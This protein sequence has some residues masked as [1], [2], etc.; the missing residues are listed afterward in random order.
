[1]APRAHL[2]LLMLAAAGAGAAPPSVSP[3]RL[4]GRQVKVD[5]SLD[6]EV[7]KQ[8]AV[9]GELTRLE[10]IEGGPGF[11][12]AEFRLFYDETA[13]YVGAR[14]EQPPGALRAHI[15]PRDYLG[16]DDAILVYL[17]PYYGSESSYV[18]KVNPLG[19]QRDSYVIQNGLVAIPW[20]GVWD[21]NGQVRDSGYSVE[22]RI[23][24]R[25]IRFPRADLQDWGFLVAVETG[26]QAQFDTWPALSANR[27]P[28]L[29]QLGKLA[30]LHGLKAGYDI[31]LLPSV[32]LRYGGRGA[33]GGG[34]AWDPFNLLNGSQ[35][36]LVDPGIDARYGFSSG[37]SA[38]LAINPDFSQVEADSD[39]LEYNIRYP[40]YLEE[41]RPFFLEGMDIFETPISLLYTRAINDPVGGLK[42][43][44]KEGRAVLGLLSG[45]D[46]VPPPTRIQLTSRS[47]APL[48][49]F[50]SGFEDMT[51]R[52]AVT[53]VGRFAYDVAPGARVG[54]MLADKRVVQGFGRGGVAQNDLASLDATVPFLTNYSVTGQA[55]L[56]RTGT[57][58]NEA[59][60]GGLY[61][62]RLRREDRSLLLQ[63]EA[64]YYSPDFRAETS[65]ITRVDQLPSQLTASYKIEPGWPWLA[66][67]RPELTA[68][69]VQDADTLARADWAL[70]PAVTL[71][72]AGNT[73]LTAGY[74]HGGERFAG[75]RFPVQSAFLDL[76]TSPLG[77]L[78]ASVELQGGSRIHYDVL[79]PFLGTGADAALLLTLRPSTASQIDLSYIKS[80]FWG[81]LS[82]TPIDDVDLM[83][84]KA[85]Y[86][87]TAQLSLRAILQLN[88]Y[89]RSL[90]SNLLLAYLYRPGTAV[91]LGVQ[92]SEP[93]GAGSTTPVERNVFVKLSYLWQ[94]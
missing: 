4:D 19:I 31:D 20:D 70:K 73:I 1:M 5:G 13:L 92:D 64:A 89:S 63:A 46:V 12:K 17:Q 48:P 22:L 87:F 10:P 77:W 94:L 29:S 23:P 3:P 40:L 36:G 80:L 90:Q 72:F 76:D 21:S 42:V 34:F 8:A 38:N 58:G 71:Q 27:G 44:G 86:N 75:S 56:S 33:A 52:Q 24:F 78:S 61:L 51:G 66:Y 41:K 35:P 85:T 14:I 88:T 25:S 16:N 67:V 7:W 83:R 79:D 2:G 28:Q 32:V 59:L 15:F 57:V 65:A 68:T 43:T 74:L 55:V 37:T 91:Y 84:L 18:F 93:I 49:A 53:T 39:Q 11:G 50:A 54:L 82:P 60:W 69:L 26:S 62:L 45:W 81:P 9:I 6:E 30:G 47:P